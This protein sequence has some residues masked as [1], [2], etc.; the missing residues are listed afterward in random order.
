MI[1]TAPF[2]RLFIFEILTGFS[3]IRCT[4]PFIV[5]YMPTHC[6]IV[7]VV[8]PALPLP[9]ILALI[10]QTLLFFVDSDAAALDVAQP[11]VAV[12]AVPANVINIVVHIRSST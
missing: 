8:I 4:I 3:P 7:L 2:P 12:V 6:V 10:T 11:N 9:V 1:L 5:I